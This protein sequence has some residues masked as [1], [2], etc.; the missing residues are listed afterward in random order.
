MKKVITPIVTFVTFLLVAGACYYDN[1]EA[2]Y[3][4]AASDCD[5][6]NVSY[7]ITVTG[8]LSGSCLSC[9]SGT[10]AAVAGNNIR[11]DTYTDLSA[12]LQAVQA[13]INHKAGYSPMPKNGGKLN[14]CSLTQFDIWIR[15]G[16]PNN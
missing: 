15:K 10:N 14:S 11:L 5:T 6:T 2:L 12:S 7:S 9:H 1:E 16:A 3:P 4:L 8:I 13:S